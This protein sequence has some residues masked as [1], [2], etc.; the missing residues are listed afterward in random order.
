MRICGSVNEFTALT[1]KRRSSPLASGGIVVRMEYRW[2]TV[3][4]REFL[5]VFSR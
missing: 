4:T 2:V 3:K 1:S 5:E